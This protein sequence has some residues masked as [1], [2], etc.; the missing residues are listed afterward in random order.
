M[1]EI[2]KKGNPKLKFREFRVSGQDRVGGAK[3]LKTIEKAMKKHRIQPPGG[4]KWRRS[5]R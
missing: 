4:C 5:T 1:M 3:S 2:Y